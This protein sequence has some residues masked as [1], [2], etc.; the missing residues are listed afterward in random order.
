MT[1]RRRRPATTDL[2]LQ[3]AKKWER[4]S[5]VLSKTGQPGAIGAGEM[6]RG[7]ALQLV[8]LITARR[9]MH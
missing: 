3:L 1:P 8:R 2:L 6:A 7:C 4:T 5:R 9:K